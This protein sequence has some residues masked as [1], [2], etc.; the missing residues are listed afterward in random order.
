M[1]TTTQLMTAEELLKLPQ[2]NFRHELIKGE[3]LTMSPP[4]AEHGAVIMNLAAPLAIYV[5][6]RKLGIVFGA[7][8]GFTVERNPD[9]VI[10]PDIAFLRRERITDLPKGYCEGAPDLAVEVNSPGDRRSKIA[11]KVERW[12]QAGA[13]AVWEVD[14][15]TRTV[16]VHRRNL[17]AVVL[18]EDDL[19]DGDDIVPGFRVPVSEIFS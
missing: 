5:K 4:G 1:S 16:S 7:E 2:D 17:D 10:A 3:L 12:L 6:Q 14:P 19:L 13:L 15:K 18:S 9:T 11:R 8:T